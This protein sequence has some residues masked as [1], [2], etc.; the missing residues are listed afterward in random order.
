RG[1]RS[2]AL[3]HAHSPARSMAR[4][5]T[6]RH[7]GAMSALL[8]KAEIQSELLAVAERLVLQE[9]RQQVCYFLWLLLLHP[10]TGAVHQMKAH[11]AGA[12]RLPHSPGGARG[13]VS[14]PVTFAP[15][16]HGWHVDGAA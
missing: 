16:E 2:H 1:P 4:K 5:R 14:P 3:W 7:H 9:L 10:M 8:P 12:C 13:L 6:Q 15:N 11:H